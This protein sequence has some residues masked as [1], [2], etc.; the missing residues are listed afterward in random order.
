MYV[1]VDKRI[2][3]LKITQWM[4]KKICSI[5]KKIGTQC[6]CMCLM[7]IALKFDSTLGVQNSFNTFKITLN[8][9]K[10]LLIY[11]VYCCHLPPLSHLVTIHINLQK[12]NQLCI[13]E[14][15][16]PISFLLLQDNVITTFYID[17]IANIEGR[18]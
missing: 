5:H 17:Y 18:M 10:H 13:H 11:S 14:F 3:Y 7:T 8:F 16:A 15:A 4:H 1:R 9:T 6:V 12:L 2:N